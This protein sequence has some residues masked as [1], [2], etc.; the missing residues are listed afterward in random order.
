MGLMEIK[1][2]LL[3]GSD[4]YIGAVLVQKLIK[5]KFNV[6]AW[7]NLYYQKSILGKYN[8]MVNFKKVDIR[9][10]NKK[11]LINI[12]AIIHLAALSNDPLGELD[13][14]LT[15]EIN[16]LATVRIAKLAKKMKVKRFIFPSSCS[17]YGIAKN[18][19]VSEKSKVNPLTTY[20]KSKIKSEKTLK[21]LADKSFCVCLPRNSTVYGFSPKLRT[22]LVVNDFTTTAVA[23][24]EIRIMSDGTPWRPLIDVRDLSDI[25]IEF[26]KIDSKKVNG[27]IINVGFN[28]N[29][30][31]V[32]EILNIIKKELPNCKVIY[33]GEHGKD[34]RSYKV[35]FNTFKKTFPNVKQ[36]WPLKKSIRNLIKQLK[37]ENFNETL[38][39]KNLYNRL[40]V[41]KDLINKNK[42]DKKLHWI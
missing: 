5:N 10:I 9:E 21:K 2:I 23:K 41:L 1:N 35:N 39:E 18:G 8:P 25:F 3:T 19:V 36:K 38:F 15:E 27:K 28:E 4:G 6:I 32:R 24:G 11:E 22:D 20:A 16:Y 40:Y 13:S 31:Q 30:L 26:L 29:N 33:T 12:D 17:I 37:S 34:A 14:K 7:D 42:V